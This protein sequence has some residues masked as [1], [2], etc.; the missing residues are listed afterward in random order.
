[1]ARKSYE[2]VMAQA[3]KN[4]VDL[5][6]IK[7]IK[8]EESII[9]LPSEPVPE[10]SDEVKEIT[11]VNAS[12]KPVKK[13]SP[14]QL[15]DDM[16]YAMPRS[17]RPKTLEG[18]YHNFTARLREDLYDYAQSISGKDKEYQSVNDYL[19]RLIARD[20]LSK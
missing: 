6:Q 3:T 4:F 13:E 7:E 8:T 16:A 18:K 15:I 20:M 9:E 19:N 2:N 5:Q 11:P 17:G 14:V 12:P 1:M 10:V